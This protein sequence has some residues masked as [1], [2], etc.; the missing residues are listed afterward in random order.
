MNEGTE[1][2]IGYRQGAGKFHTNLSCASTSSRSYATPTTFVPTAKEEC[3][4]CIN[5]TRKPATNDNIVAAWNAAGRKG[6]SQE[7]IN[8]RAIEMMIQV[9]MS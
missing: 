5:G 2:T 9:A 4:K 6:M 1:A 3:Q 8:Q 7:Y